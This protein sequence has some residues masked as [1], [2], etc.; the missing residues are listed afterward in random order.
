MIELIGLKEKA[1]DRVKTLSGGQQR[2]LD[3]G[4]GIIGNPELLFLDEP[5]TGLDPSGRRDTWDLIRQLTSLGTTVMLT[6]HYMDE[7]EALADRVAVLNNAEIVAAGTPTSIGGRDS[8]EV[9][10]RFLLPDGVAV[11][12]IPVA[13]DSLEQGLVEIRTGDELRLLHELTGWALE[14]DHALTGLSVVRVTLEDVYLHLTRDAAEPIE[15]RSNEHD[16]RPMPPP[17]TACRHPD[18]PA[19]FHGLSDVRLV[20]RQVWYEQ[21]SFWLNPLGAFFTLGFSVIF[22][23]LLGAIAGNSKIGSGYGAVK[24]VQ[25]YLASF[26]AYAI[27]AA[28]FTVLAQTLVNRREMGLLKRLRLSPVPTWSLLSA[29]FLSTMIIALLQVGILLVV[30]TL[31]FGDYLPAHGLAFILTIV[32]GMFSFTAL[33]IGMSTLVPNADAAGPMI[34]IVFFLL[35]AV[36][37]AVLPDQARHHPGQHL[38]LLPGPPP[39]HGVAGLVQP[40]P[41]RQPLGLARPLGHGHLGRGRRPRGTTPLAL[42]SPSGLTSPLRWGD[43]ILRQTDHRARRVGTD[44]PQPAQKGRQLG[45]RERRQLSGRAVQN[46]AGPPGRLLPRSGGLDQLGPA[47][48]RVGLA[49][50]QAL[51]LEIVD[52][53]RHVGRIGTEDRGELAHGARGRVDAP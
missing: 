34:S 38:G 1:D 24:L 35:L 43:P 28:C 12:D 6:T 41:R 47:I 42:G 27:M 21:L 4:L 3:V 5:T 29:I 52:H 25:Y 40:A 15:K 10:I 11:S 7:V 2:R 14:H 44:G 20:G 22:L 31:G 33:G 19:S 51:P 50:H 16:A 53:D 8:S 30:G 9:T 45:L 36:L 39:H 23:V 48:G 32:V 17:V 18:P 49:L 13:V 46:V 37:R 26:I